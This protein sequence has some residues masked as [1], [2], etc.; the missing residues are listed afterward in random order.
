MRRPGTLLLLL[1]LLIALPVQLPASDATRIQRDGV[2]MR[3]S[4]QATRRYAGCLERPIFTR[5]TALLRRYA[6]HDSRFTAVRKRLQAYA[7]T[8]ISA[9]YVPP[10]IL[11]GY[12]FETIYL[13]MRSRNDVVKLADAPPFDYSVLYGDPVDPR[14]SQEIAMALFGD[15]VVRRDPLGAHDLAAILPASQEE[16]A[17]LTDL[18][19]HLEA[20]IPAGSDVAFGRSELRGALATALY[21]LSGLRSD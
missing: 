6:P 19:P 1:A 12:L 5:S 20:C 11:Q 8:D 13:R 10:E 14:S 7:C 4:R 2:A 3:D 15:C 21:H 17:L 16:A 9:V 18:R